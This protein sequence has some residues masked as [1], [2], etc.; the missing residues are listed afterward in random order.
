MMMD[1]T[2]VVDTDAIL[3]AGV[4]KEL[5]SIYTDLEERALFSYPFPQI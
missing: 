2:T 3:K 5:L 1:E 4:R